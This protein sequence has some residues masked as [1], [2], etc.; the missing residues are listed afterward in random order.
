MR[1]VWM[2]TVVVLAAA[3]L[4]APALAQTK[5]VRG[6]VTAMG[7]DTITVTVKGA[8]HVFKVEPATQ[9]IAT[10]AGT[11]AKAAAEKG[12]P[13]PKLADF[14]KVGQHVEVHY[15]DVAGTKIA[16]EVRPV[17]A[18]GEAEAAEPAA[19]SSVSGSIVSVTV[20]TLV[21]KAGE[22]EMKFAVNPK[23]KVTGTG[24]STKTKELKEAGKPTVI[25]EFLKPNDRVVV[26]YEEGA[27]PTATSVRVT[28]KALK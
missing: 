10:G 8:E 26:T 23:T 7:A 9:L 19:G 21:V 6:P 20:D 22:K 27:T 16:T 14:V 18:S 5:W 12:K 25:T 3:L 15:K 2:L 1:R 4:A 13:G 28:Q 24:A 11:A 17:A